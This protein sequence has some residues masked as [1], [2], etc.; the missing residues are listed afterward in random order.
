MPQI[1]FAHKEYDMPLMV[2]PGNV[3]GHRAV[4]GRQRLMKL[5]ADTERSG[6]TDPEQR[7]RDN[8]KIAERK[9]GPAARG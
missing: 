8:I 3:G 7:S 4:A 5:L 6:E 9:P 2:D 1:A